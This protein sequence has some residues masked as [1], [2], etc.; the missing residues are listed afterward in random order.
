[1]SRP[2][3]LGVSAAVATVALITGACTTGKHNREPTSTTSTTSK[4]SAVPT[5][6]IAV[7]PPSFV[8]DASG[9]RHGITDTV[10]VRIR[11][12]TSGEARVSFVQHDVAGTGPQWAAAGWNAVLVATLTTGAPIAGREIE[13]DVTGA[14]DGTSAGALLTVAVIALMRGDQLAS[15]VTMTGAVNPDGSIAPADGMLEKIDSAAAGHATRMLIPVG[16]RDTKAAAGDGID[17]IERARRRNL[18]VSETPDVYDAYRAFTREALP[19]LPA[20]RTT[21]LDERAYNRIRPRVEA[22]IAKYEATRRSV[23]TLAPSVQQD[24]LPFVR[25]ATR[26]ARDASK[27]GGQG[28]QAGALAKAVNAAS[29]MSATAQVGQWFPTLLSEGVKPFVSQLQA[30]SAAAGVSGL[31]ATLKSFAPQTVGD[32]DALLTAYGY[33]QD[34]VSSARFAQRLFHAPAPSPD[35]AVTWAAQGAVYYEL[36]PA[37]VA[38]AKDTLAAGQGLGGVPSRTTADQVAAADLF[39]HAAIANLGAFRSSVIPALARAQHADLIVAEQGLAAA[40]SEF[41]LVRTG[42]ELLRVLPSYFANSATTDLAQLGGAMSLY[43]RSADLLSRYTTLGSV[44]PETLALT[45]FANG[46]AFNS[47][48]EHAQSQLAA[49]LGSLRARGV[50][51]VVAAADN[52]VA[53]V[54]QNGGVSDQFAALG[55]YWNGYLHC[56]V[57]AYLGGFAEL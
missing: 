43:V 16:T 34:A 21:R 45:G 44:D 37:L 42:D 33:A 36:A 57:L 2:R 38:A 51:P 39:R 11:P 24:L 14:A 17:L 35:V 50:D 20:P 48:I 55:E 27:L 15:G 12:S 23:E 8:T 53:S 18:Q 29:L 1:M 30:N 19:Q 56:R 10:V 40:D 5:R 13:F 54:D 32:A 52:E 28:L 3:W 49:T 4:F 41:A 47:A 6:E 22:W 26:D 9:K 7:H 46:D 25:A 31:V